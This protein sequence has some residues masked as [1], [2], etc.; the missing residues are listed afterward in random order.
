MDAVEI[1]RDDVVRE[2]VVARISHTDAV[3][4]IVR[5]S[6]VEECVVARRIQVDAI[7]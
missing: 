4:W 6:V 7:L 3:L 1:F 5:D 2:R